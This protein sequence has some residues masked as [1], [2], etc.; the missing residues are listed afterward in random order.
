MMLRFML[1]SFI[2]IG[3]AIAVMF[4][5]LSAREWLSAGLERLQHILDGLA[6]MGDRIMDIKETLEE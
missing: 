1:L 4:D 2:L 3:L 5:L 6:D